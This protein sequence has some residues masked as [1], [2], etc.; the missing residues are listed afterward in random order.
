MKTKIAI[1]KVLQAYLQDCISS[2]R[3]LRSSG[4]FSRQAQ[5]S[6]QAVVLYLLTLPKRSLAVSLD[7]FL[8]HYYGATAPIMSKSSISKARYKLSHRLFI[9]WNQLLC[10]EAYAHSA[11]KTWKGD[12]LYGIDGSTGTI[13]DS[14]S[15]RAVFGLRKNQHDQGALARV[16]VCYDVLN[17]FC[18]RTAIVAYTTS[19]RAVAYKWA[20]RMDTSGIY[21]YDRGFA[22]FVHFWLLN[23]YN[24]S[25]VIRCKLGFNKEVKAFVDSNDQSR[26][27]ELSASHK[28][29]KKLREMGMN[30]GKTTTVTLR[31]VKVKLDDGSIEVLITNLLDSEQYPD[32]CFKELYFM[33]WGVEVF[34]DK[35]KNQMEVEI[36]SG[37]KPEAIKQE[38]YASVFVYNLQSL[39]LADCIP[40]IEKKNAG[41][42]KPHQINR[43]V[44]FGLL[45]VKILQIFLLA[46]PSQVLKNLKI[47]FLKNTLAVVPNRH[48]PRN[49]NKKRQR[50]RFRQNTNFARAA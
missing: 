26:V 3:F 28:A 48:N 18:T 7:D 23:G 22:S 32:Q 13:P 40:E 30:L 36:F 12:L 33:R 4:A 2:K 19:E 35:F 39:L 8:E 21:I 14:P 25:F 16:L 9:A 46:D 1:I 50:D 31:L 15:T 47:K 43:N 20:Q 27:V 37:R 49:K 10:N 44:S 29:R 42:D 11:P 38:F 34:F 5:L 17:H 45:K 6:Y 24:K 41:K